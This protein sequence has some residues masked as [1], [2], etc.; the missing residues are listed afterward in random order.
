MEF[1]GN[2][3][4][5]L[6]FS[7]EQHT[8]PDCLL[9]QAAGGKH[10][11][12]GCSSQ[13]LPLFLEHVLCYS[14]VYQEDRSSKDCGVIFKE[15]LLKSTYPC[16]AMTGTQLGQNIPHSETAVCMVRAGHASCSFPSALLFCWSFSFSF[17]FFNELIQIKRCAN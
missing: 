10:R 5:C 16:V 8:F 1:H 9:Q 7:A 15:C 4:L 6:P 14:R 17:S 2:R 11:D 12:L 13:L 3:T